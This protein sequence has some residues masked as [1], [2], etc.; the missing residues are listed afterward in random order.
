MVCRLLC[1]LAGAAAGFFAGFVVVMAGANSG[2]DTGAI[3]LFLGSLLAGPGA[4]AGA[5]VGGA[6]DWWGF[7]SRD[8][9]SPRQARGRDESESGE[10]AA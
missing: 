8:E 4:I 6:A 9:R 3:I 1:S 7:P 10:V 5:I 2:S